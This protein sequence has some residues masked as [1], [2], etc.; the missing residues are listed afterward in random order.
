[1]RRFNLCI[2]VSLKIRIRYS[3]SLFFTKR[4]ILPPRKEV[5][6][7]NTLTVEKKGNYNMS[8]IEAAISRRA[9]LLTILRMV[10]RPAGSLAGGKL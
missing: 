10:V 8:S 5:I 4:V 9:H 1:M 3:V 2:H 7:H 6:L